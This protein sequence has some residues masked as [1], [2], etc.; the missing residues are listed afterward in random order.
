M[1]LKRSRLSPGDP[2]EENDSN[3]KQWEDA[4][5]PVCMEHPHNAILLTCS[6]HGRGC[7][8]FICDTS[9]R[10]SNCFDQFRKSFLSDDPEALDKP[11]QLVCPLCRGSVSGWVVVEPARELMNAKVRSCASETCDYS[12]SYK[13]LRRHARLVHPLARPADVDPEM[14][15]NWRRL[16][17]ER[18]LGDL[19]STLRMS[20]ENEI[21]E[22]GWLIMFFLVRFIGP[23]RGSDGSRGGDTVRALRRLWYDGEAEDEGAG[24]Q[25]DGPGPSRY[26]RRRSNPDATD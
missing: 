4:R 2:P 15:H 10:H 17:R 22:G 20:M 23:P 9:Y 25:E 19:L 12:G 7:R 21:N 14:Q 6:S 11:K 18:D 13:E 5:C 24:G 1:P 3:S 8:P 16:E 26:V